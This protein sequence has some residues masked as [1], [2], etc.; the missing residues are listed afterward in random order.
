MSL[1]TNIGLRALLTSQAALDTIGHNV[2]NANTEGFSRQNLLISNSR[3][4]N[5]RGLQLGHG[6]QADQVVRSVDE[7]LNGRI[8]RQASTIGRLD[9][10]LVEMQSVEAL[11]GEPGGDGFGALLDGIFESLSALS[12]NTEDIV[13]RTGAVQSTEDLITRFHQ[14]SNEISQLQSDAQIKAQSLSDGVNV[15]ASRIVDLNQ[16]ITQIE[17]VSGTVA[18]D[19]RDQRDVALMALA[20]R[21]D[22]QV[23][24]NTE[25]AVQVQVDG[26]LLVGASNV[27][28]MSVDIS[29]DGQIEVRLEGGVRPVDPSGGE[30]A[31]LI[32]FSR[33]FASEVGA[34]LDAYALEI[35]RALNSAHSTGVPLDGGF[36][37]LRASNAVTDVD[38]DGE[39][40]DELLRDAG[41]PF[42]VNTGALYVHVID[43]TTQEVRTER[44]DV[45]PSR[46]T[47]QG[48]LDAISS[49]DGLTA[50]LDTFGRVDIDATSGNRFHFG[51]PI[52]S[53]PD[54]E[55]TFGG[56]RAT[57]VSA[58]D[59]PFSLAGP[60]TIDITGPG[61][62]FSVTVD[63]A[64][65]ET[66]GEGTAEEIAA[67][68]NADANFTGANLQAS[69]VGERV[70]IQTV[71]EGSAESFQITGGTALT[72]LGIAPGT[73]AG[74]DLAVQ[75]ELSG[76]YDGLAN[77]RWTFEPLG[78]GVI[79]T[80]PGLE[81]AVRDQ[82][83][84]VL[85]TLD[86]GAGYA[87]GNAID[88]ADG[89]SV[90]FTV[91]EVRASDGHAFATDV[92]A[93]SD[94]SDVLVAFGL[95]AYLTGTDA[96]TID[97]RD[98]IRRDPRLL[99][100]SATGAV[101][102]GGALLDMIGAQSA[103]VTALG[104]TLGEYYGEI[105]GDVGFQIAS[106][107]SAQSI[108]SDLMSS[109]EAQREEVSG[110]NVDEELVRMIQYEQAYSAA[111][112][113]LQVITQ[114]NDTVLALV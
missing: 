75:V 43:E 76:T 68:L 10:Q 52:N 61:G 65:F 9:A 16:E 101:G 58:F 82:N 88:I 107:Q 80:T 36:T 57:T 17:A 28:P 24:E 111:A 34:G 45:D 27:H 110:V 38:G 113:Y 98:D 2:A 50:R 78:D 109:L 90:S 54:A 15:L 60:A 53:A 59:G 12:A 108:E 5:L 63:P 40:A 102:D 33:A 62:P 32:E 72:A 35:A 93:D 8:V 48:F 44:I 81:V 13:N 83:G 4:L 30:I 31:G 105:V 64:T 1:S 104:G 100:A 29:A 14:V 74:Q 71:G 69:V 84:A 77:D 70:A 18:N 51:R 96:R 56:G 39:V 25:G 3:P 114:L 26:Q 86:V 66:V 97:I 87:P 7:L 112:Q 55:G 99:A 11:L 67:A 94:T 22:I 46:M 21:V 73:Y 23:R 103:D 95:N 37:Q 92:I 19:L 6:V 91:G 89:M 85:V 20:E 47:V 106:A 49:I 42:D 79:G 41:L